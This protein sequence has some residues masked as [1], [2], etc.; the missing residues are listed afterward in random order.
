[1]LHTIRQDLSQAI[2]AL[3]RAPSFTLTVLLTLAL[4]IGVNVAV[5]SVV[6][7][8]LL[9]PLPFRDADRV[10][11][12]SSGNGATTLSEPEIVDLRRDAATLASVGTFT[13]TP[14]NITGS[15]A[16]AERVLLARVDAGF[17]TTLQ[18]TFLQGRGFLPDED[19]AG[20]PDVVVISHGL[21]QRRFFQDD[22]VIGKTITVNGTP[23]TIVGVVRPEFTYPSTQV[24]VW[25]PLRLD[26][27]AM[28]TRN[29]HYLGT[30]GR[31][32]PDASI[33]AAHA[34]LRTIRDR[35]LLEYPESYN[36]ERPLQVDVRPIRDRIVGRSQP[37]LVALF[38]AVGFVLL[39]ACA[40]VA[41]LLILRGEHRRHELALRSALGATGARLVKEPALE[42]AVLAIGGTALGMAA[43]WPTLRMLLALVPDALPRTGEIAIDASALLFAAATC[44]LACL[45]FAVVPLVQAVRVRSLESLNSSRGAGTSGGRAARRVRRSLVVAEVALAVVMLAGA[46]MFLRTLGGLQRTELGF[47][48]QDILTASVTLPSGAYDGPR[49]HAFVERVL[50]QARALPGVRSAAAMAWAPIVQRAGNWSIVTEDR[51]L[52]TVAEAPTAAPQQV[53][54]GLFEALDI[55]LRAGR[56]FTEADRA[57]AAPVAIVNEQLANELWG[58][59]D[60]VGKR[61]R[62]WSGNPPLVTVV[63]VV[64]DTRS[65]GITEPVP[66]TMYFPH[67]Q[68][69]QTAYFTSQTMTLV[70]RLTSGA[71]PPANGVRE[72]VNALD[73]SIPLADVR[74]MSAIVAST[75]ATQRFT[76]TVLGALASL[77]L[78]LAAVGIYG[79]ISY[80]VTQRRREFGVRIALGAAWSRVAGVVLREG[81]G[82]ATAG[83]VI[84]GL[85]AFALDRVLRS[86]LEGVAPLDLPALGAV[87]AVLLGVSLLA[88]LAPARRAARVNPVETLRSE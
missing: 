69:G 38:G 54:P 68:A 28:V 33:A 3:G 35:W 14:G 57:D 36:L 40:N 62:V 15:D 5:F 6:N 84:G 86:L 61:F 51:P 13:L 46:T 79:V 12:L 50:E 39:I 31:L 65:E 60:V 75:I 70:L 53:T 2:R 16:D 1:M 8:V 10:I 7:G 56:T 71:A 67:A 23:R 63:G 49:S 32:A 55:P 74:T 37:Y 17:F 27:A 73:R 34:E 21:W 45:A 85:G 42:G 72:A 58:T 24:A 77:A 82:L 22:A 81:V 18:P 48:T 11:Q 64:G 47:A 20:A 43:A 26:R 52:S 83:L 29:N 59:T 41:N 78:V 88:G 9:R 19:A 4:G 87:A 66:G 80:G 44:A 30:I 25:T 76:T